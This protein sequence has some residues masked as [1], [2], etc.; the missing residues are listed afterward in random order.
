M[1]KILKIRFSN[2]GRFVGDHEVDFSEKSNIM[3]VDAINKN[4]G[5][6]SGSGKTTIFL[7]LEYVLGINDIPATALQSRLTKDPMSASV[8]ALIGQEIY[9]ITRNI[10]KGLSIVS[11]LKSVS[12]SSSIAEDELRSLIG[13]P[14]KLLRPLIHKRQNEGGFFLSKTPSKMHSFLMDCLDMKDYEAKIKKAE[15]DENTV[16]ETIK[17]LDFAIQEKKQDLI[18]AQAVLGSLLEP[19]K[20]I[21]PSVIFDIESKLKKTADL[22][23]SETEKHSIELSKILKPEAPDIKDNEDILSKIKAQEL[24]ITELELFIKSS[25]DKELSL[26]LDRQ[27]RSVSLQKDLSLA[28]SQVISLKAATK[29][30]ADQQREFDAIKKEIEHAKGESC[31]TCRQKLQG[32]NMQEILSRLADR[33]KR[34]YVSIQESSAAIADLP[35]WESK[36]LTAEDQIKSLNLEM[37][38][39]N[40]EIDS[41]KKAISLTR[42]GLAAL[43][44][45][46]DRYRNSQLQAYKETLKS[47][48]S[49]ISALSSEHTSKMVLLNGSLRAYEMALS[50]AKMRLQKESLDLERYQA[51]MIRWN[52][53]ISQISLRLDS[54]EKEREDAKRKLIVTKEA[55]RFVKSYSNQ[56]FQ[57]SLSMVAE[58]ATK[59]LSRVPNTST[60]TIM[61]DSS[62]TTQSGTI[63]EEVVPV[64]SIDGE[65]GIPVDS[66]SGGERAAVDLAVDLAVIDMIESRT[67]KGID[68]FALDEPFDGLDSVCKENCLEVLKNHMSDRKIIIVDHSN[69][70]K[71]MVSD[72]IVVIREGNVSSIGKAQQ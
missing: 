25:E 10:K 22:V 13:I 29:N 41:A 63:K 31:P 66:L 71:Q 38:Q 11:A 65:V 17:V 69:E 37:I 27:K 36:I 14:I 68:L 16:E 12:G 42:T 6:S 55:V 33:A 7:A 26:K 45:E 39:V 54:L 4:T 49:T 50:D 62:R 35:S 56:L 24:S 64:L 32:G 20:T 19:Q 2:F 21:E 60:A 48:E 23:R 58:N 40:P 18:S 46:K 51:D 52:K 28:K 61:F 34:I 30:M 67:G 44:V 59:I 72:K 53:S 43:F 9:E 57:D 5:G 8:T 1:F 3:Q 70:T 15:L 47:Y